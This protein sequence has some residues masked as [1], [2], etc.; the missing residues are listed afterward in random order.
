MNFILPEGFIESK[1]AVRCGQYA[2]EFWRFACEEMKLD[3]PSFL[4]NE[5]LDRVYR[6]FGD[7][8][9][10]ARNSYGA[11]CGYDSVQWF[12]THGFKIYDAEDLI[13]NNATVQP[14]ESLLDLFAV[15][16]VVVIL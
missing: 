10:V 15:S 2:M 14:I 12:T 11:G 13:V 1:S 6:D 7:D 3:I 5:W 9:T 8:L 4:K 16:G